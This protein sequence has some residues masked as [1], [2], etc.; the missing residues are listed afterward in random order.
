MKGQREILSSHHSGPLRVHF[1]DEWR[2]VLILYVILYHL[3]YDLAVLF[4]PDIP[5][6]FS[7]WMETLRDTMTGMLIFISGISCRFSHSNALRGGRLLLIALA[8]TLVTWLVMPEQLIIF[9]I[10]HFFSVSMLLYA[11][12]ERLLRPVPPWWGAGISLLLFFTTYR[13]RVGHLGI[14][15]PL[16]FQLPEGL[17]ENFLCFVLGLP[18]QGFSSADYYPLLPWIFLFLAGSFI[19]PLLQEG[20]APAFF[21]QRHVRWLAF[22][23]RHTL[24]LYLVHQPVLLAILT[25]IYH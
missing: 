14:I 19:G 15:R 8:L 23:G 16:V 4:P 17:R 21:Y 3:L 10:L 12:L 20:R 18:T 13:L 24:L 9:G 22:T 25:L 1:I 11:L 6:M 7:D 2:G 5:W